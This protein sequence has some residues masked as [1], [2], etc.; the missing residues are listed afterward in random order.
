MIDIV[1]EEN[2]DI[3]FQ[4]RNPWSSLSEKENKLFNEFLLEYQKYK[5]IREQKENNKRIFFLNKKRF[6]SYFKGGISIY[7]ILLNSNIYIYKLK[8]ISSLL[9]CQNLFF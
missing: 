3:I 1:K 4:V 7:P 9:N 5:G 8:D 2:N 6:E